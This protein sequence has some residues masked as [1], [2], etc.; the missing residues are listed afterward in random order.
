MFSDLVCKFM[1]ISVRNT[2]VD[3][4]SERSV[5]NFTQTWFGFK[6]YELY[7]RFAAADLVYLLMTM[8]IFL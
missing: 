8:E 1:M 6:D 3:E 5:Q 4:H 7:F 2:L